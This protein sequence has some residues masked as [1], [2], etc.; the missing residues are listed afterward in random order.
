MTRITDLAQLPHFD[1][2]KIELDLAISVLIET[3]TQNIVMTSHWM[4]DK[5]LNDEYLDWI[6]K[7]DLKDPGVEC[8]VLKTKY[9]FWREIVA[10]VKGD[11]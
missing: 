3:M 10:S 6:G 8:D 9:E 11:Q 2:S 7:F 1:L 5:N 4:Q